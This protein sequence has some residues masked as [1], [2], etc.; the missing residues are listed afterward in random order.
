MTNQRLIAVKTTLSRPDDYKSIVHLIKNTYK[1]CEIYLF[2]FQ[3]DM[4][5]KGRVVL[6]YIY[7]LCSL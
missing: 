3:L 7:K 2:C 4:K 1:K 5:L 6:L